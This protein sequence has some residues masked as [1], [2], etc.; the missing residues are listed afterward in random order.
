MKID[1]AYV[2]LLL[3][4]VVLCLIAVTIKYVMSEGVKAQAS[5]TLSPPVTPTTPTAP[6]T[7][8]PVVFIRN[9]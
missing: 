6:P 8:N 3:T 5:V 9:V 4:V 7:R 1:D 2:K